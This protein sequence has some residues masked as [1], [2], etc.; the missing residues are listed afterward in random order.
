VKKNKRW[1]F[2][3]IIAF[4][5][6]FWL[7]LETST[8][9]SRRL[10]FYGPKKVVKAGD[11]L[12]Y[13]LPQNVI[14]L[15]GGNTKKGFSRIAMVMLKEYRDDSYRI[16]GLWE[17]IQYEKNKL[18]DIPVYILGE[19]ALFETDTN[20]K[21][22][23]RVEGVTVLAQSADT[24]KHVSDALFKHKPYYTFPS[25]LVLIDG[26]NHVR[27]YYDA[28]YVAEVK[29]MTE[30]YKHLRLREEKNQMVKDNEITNKH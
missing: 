23:G 29:R 1:I 19:R 20:M 8:I 22:V 3:L 5:S 24:L 10:P 17:Y 12:F 2:L 14:D 26:N 6:A 13:T 9:N 27:G 30:E 18:K 15:S 7:I 25:C 21:A 16:A 4:P 28:R 11:T